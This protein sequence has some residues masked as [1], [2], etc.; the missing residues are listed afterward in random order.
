MHWSKITG[1]E[2]LASHCDHWSHNRQHYTRMCGTNT[3][4]SVTIIDRE[5]L[6]ETALQGKIKCVEKGSE[7]AHQR[8]DPRTRH[9]SSPSHVEEEYGVWRIIE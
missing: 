2:G 8:S 1:D 3:S 4:S 7:R 6:Q 5:A 9:N